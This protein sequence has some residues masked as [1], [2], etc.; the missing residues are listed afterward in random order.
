MKDT[1]Y[2]ARLTH[3]M[4]GL[5]HTP[6]LYVWCPESIVYNDLV[7]MDRKESAQ[8]RVTWQA[9]SDANID[10]AVTNTLAVPAGS[11][12]LY[13]CARPVLNAEE[14]QRLQGFVAKG[15]TLLCAFEGQP[16]TPDG[17]AIAQ[18][19]KLPTK[20]LVSLQLTPKALQ[21]AN[22]QLCRTHNWDTK[23]P[24]VKTYLYQRDG[25]RVHLVNNTSLTDPASLLLPWAATDLLSGKALRKGSALTVA[26]GLY[27]LVTER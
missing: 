15:G 27:A 1:F 5:K 3:A 4:G 6:P 14:F 21:T 13:S 2:S 10:Y 24:A 26:P 9:L 8:W 16:E 25:K 7:D 18:W 11:V 23:L 12:V 20:Q 19:Q 17:A 22:A